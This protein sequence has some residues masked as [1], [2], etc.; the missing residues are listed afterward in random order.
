MALTPQAGIAM[1]M[2][3]LVAERFPDYGTLVLSTVVVSTVFFELLG[4]FLVRHVLR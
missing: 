3:L 4:P 2:A 1:G